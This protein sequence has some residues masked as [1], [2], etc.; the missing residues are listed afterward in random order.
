MTNI[1][2]LKN[3]SQGFLSAFVKHFRLTTQDDVSNKLGLTEK[4]FDNYNIFCYDIY[5]NKSKNVIIIT[6]INSAL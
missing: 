2:K 3:L 4:Y 1:P 6:Q 5:K